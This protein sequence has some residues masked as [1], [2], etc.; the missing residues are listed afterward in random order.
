LDQAKPGFKMGGSEHLRWVGKDWLSIHLIP[1]I[2]S[3]SRAMDME[4]VGRWRHMGK[5]FLPGTPA[6]DI[7]ITAIAFDNAW[8]GLR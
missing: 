3:L 6:A 4:V 2:S 7:G 5:I 8:C 1:M